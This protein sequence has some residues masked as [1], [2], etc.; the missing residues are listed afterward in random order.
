MLR[1][2]HLWLFSEGF[3][4]T[5]IAALLTPH[6]HMLTQGVHLPSSLCPLPL[7]TTDMQ[8]HTPAA[9]NRGLIQGGHTTDPAGPLSRTVIWTW[10]AA[11]QRPQCCWEL[12]KS[13]PVRAAH[14]VLLS[15]AALTMIS[16]AKTRVL[17]KECHSWFSPAH[18]GEE[19]GWKTLSWAVYDITVCHYILEARFNRVW[20]L[21][22]LPSGAAWPQT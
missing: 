18:S 12:L 5:T 16:S 9:N 14:N 3:F 7:C 8:K 10:A 19:M 11:M 6:L 21:C 4:P 2:S 13:T 1:S 15:S 20:I 22:F 17:S